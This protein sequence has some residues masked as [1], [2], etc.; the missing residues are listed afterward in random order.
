MCVSPAICDHLEKGCSSVMVEVATISPHVDNG[1]VVVRGFSFVVQLMMLLYIRD[2]ITK[3]KNYYNER[4]VSL[5]E[6]SIIVTG[7]PCKSGMR[8]NLEKFLETCFETPHKAY[9]ITFLPEHEEY[10]A[11]EEEKE[12]VVEQMKVAMREG[13]GRGGLEE[14]LMEI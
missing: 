6:F 7:L 14:K 5:S 13:R 12:R 10:Y 4:N 2:L 3:T 11:M 8:K 9:A 1:E